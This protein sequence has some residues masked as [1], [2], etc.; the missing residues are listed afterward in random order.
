MAEV[1][2][3]ADDSVDETKD[4]VSVSEAESEDSLGEIDDDCPDDVSETDDVV[5][6]SNGAEIVGE[7]DNE[8]PGDEGEEGDGSTGE[9]E[10][11]PV[12]DTEED[13]PAGTEDT[14]GPEGS[15]VAETTHDESGTGSGNDTEETPAAVEVKLFPLI[16]CL[17]P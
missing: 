4:E 12:E 7:G 6:K 15:G 10:N 2:E 9:I 14:N 5:S 1:D 17:L 3:V 11:W 13:W 8:G 16:P